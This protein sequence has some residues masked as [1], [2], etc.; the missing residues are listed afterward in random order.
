MTTWIEARLTNKANISPETSHL[1][2]MAFAS[3]C[4]HREYLETNLAQESCL[5]A[6]AFF[7]DVPNDILECAQVRCPWN[8]TIF[9]P[10]ATGVPPHVLVMAEFEELKEK[11]DKL[12][13]G[14]TGDIASMMD[15]RGVGGSEFHTNCILD[16]IAASQNK[17]GEF[18]RMSPHTQGANND[19]SEPDSNNNDFFIADEGDIEALNCLND[20]KNRSREEQGLICQRAVNASMRAVKKQKLKLGYHHGKLQCLPAHWKFPRMT[21]KQLVEN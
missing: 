21:C 13:T 1:I 19:F 6:S 10:N 8:K 11:F 12:R 17:I 20:T 18:L 16:A 9:T 14:I 2:L 15:A 3:L 4:Y 7:K 5:R